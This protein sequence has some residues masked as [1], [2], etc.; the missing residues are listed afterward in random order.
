MMMAI[1]SLRLCSIET[2]ELVALGGHDVLEG[3]REP[4]VE[5]GSGKGVTQ[6]VRGEF[7]L[8]FLELRG[9]ARRRKWRGKIQ[10]EACVDPRFSG[11]RGSSL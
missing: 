10:V 9:T 2:T 11:H 7:V 4:G 6:Q 3:A 5:N 8:M 1:K